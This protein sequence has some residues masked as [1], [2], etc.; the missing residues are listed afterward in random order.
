VATF[1]GVYGAHEAVL[2]RIEPSTVKKE[3]SK[4]P[5]HKRMATQRFQPPQTIHEL[6]QFVGRPLLMRVG[7]ASVAFYLTGAAQAYIGSR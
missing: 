6:M 5:P 2:S 7:A 4:L 3:E 1:C